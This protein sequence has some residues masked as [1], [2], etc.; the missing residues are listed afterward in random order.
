[1]ANDRRAAEVMQALAELDGAELAVVID[2]TIS[3]HPA[4]THAALKAWGNT[5]RERR[6]S[7]R[8]AKLRYPRE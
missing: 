6:I 7:L 3:S 5:I 2:G 8:E 1:M 4:V